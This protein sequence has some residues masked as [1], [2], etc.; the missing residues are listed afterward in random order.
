M[1]VIEAFDLLAQAEQSAVVQAAALGPV[2]TDRLAVLT[3]HAA[4][5]S[6]A[7]FGAFEAGRLVGYTYGARCQFGQWWFDQIAPAISAAGHDP[8]LVDVHAV[9]ELHVLPG[10]QGR[11]IGFALVRALL[12]D[13]AASRVLLSTYDNESVARRFYRRLG[14][15]DLLVD[16][17]FEVTSQP[18]AL[19]GAFLP[20]ATSPPGST[21]VK[22]QNRSMDRP[23]LGGYLSRG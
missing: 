17:R 19:M 7:A 9:T 18:F 15:V 10:H 5:P 20:L 21:S 1:V 11:G 16:F 14:F 6:F 3:R 8:W 4:Y 12:A 13:V 23:T 22:S 2:P